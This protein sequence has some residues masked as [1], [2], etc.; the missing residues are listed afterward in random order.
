M[1]IEE[2]TSLEEFQGRS[3]KILEK[4]KEIRKSKNPAYAGEHD[5][6]QNFKTIAKYLEIRPIA[7][8][9]IYLWKHISSILSYAKDEEVP[10]AE[11]M[12][13][14]FAD[15]I[16]YLLILYS[17]YIEEKEFDDKEE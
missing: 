4:A 6:H 5:F 17:L 12:E 14:R 15:C 9:S 16:N 11:P 10:Q 3:E 13:T 7:V 2:G 8:A 1:D